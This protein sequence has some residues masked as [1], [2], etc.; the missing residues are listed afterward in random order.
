MLAFNVGVYVP[1]TV[2]MEGLTPPTG[3]HSGNGT[4]GP[5]LPRF[6][7]SIRVTV[8]MQQPQ[9]QGTNSILNLDIKKDPTHRNRP[10]IGGCQGIVGGGGWK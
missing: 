6:G 1:P 2:P 10:Q 9:L 3:F 5:C 7:L 8:N 4:G